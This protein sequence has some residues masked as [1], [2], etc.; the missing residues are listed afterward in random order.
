MATIN[1]DA[2]FLDR[3]IEELLS[4]YYIQRYFGGHLDGDLK[5]SSYEHSLSDFTSP[6]TFEYLMARLKDRGE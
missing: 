2:E 4:Q 1:K 3:C 6:D 5:V